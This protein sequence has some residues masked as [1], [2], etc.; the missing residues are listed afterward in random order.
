MS[1]PALCVGQEARA[2]H[3]LKVVSFD[4]FLTR[5]EFL[6][7]PDMARWSNNAPAGEC[8]SKLPK[9]RIEIHQA[10]ASQ[11]GTAKRLYS[12]PNRAA[13]PSQTMSFSSRK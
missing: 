13:D 4:L 3:L 9:I 2:L 11:S 10:I 6:E 8:D 5:S 1:W 7:P 12:I